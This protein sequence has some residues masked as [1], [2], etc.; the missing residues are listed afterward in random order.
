MA[1]FDHMDEKVILDEQLGENISPVILINKFNVKPEEADQFL[2]A[3]ADDATY[4]KSQPGFISAQFH[5]GIENDDLFVNYAV[6]DIV[7]VLK[8]LLAT[9]TWRP[10]C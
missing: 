6:G 7:C 1:K 9:L 8:R 3:W 5:Q 4:F 2:K 10:C